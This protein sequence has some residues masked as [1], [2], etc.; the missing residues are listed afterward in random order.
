[1]VPYNLFAAGVRSFRVKPGVVETEL[2]AL[3]EVFLIDPHKDLTP[4][5]DVGT[6]LWERRL[7]HITYDVIN[8]FADGD[9]ADREAFYEE[10]DQVEGL[11]ARSS[12]EKV[13]R[14]E[15]MAMNVQ[16]DTQAL[17]AKKAASQVL[18]LDPVARKAIAAQFETNP[19]RWS[20]RFMDVVGDAFVD[21]LRRRDVALVAEPLDASARDLV[22]S[23]RFDVVFQ[24]H[25]ALGKSVEFAGQAARMRDPRAARAELTKGMFGPET[26]R[27]LL[28]EAIR[29]NQQSVMSGGSPIDQKAVDLNWLAQVIQPVL[30]ELGSE[31]VA[32]ILTILDTVTHDAL[33]NVLIG[34]LQRALV[35]REN[36]ILER[37]GSMSIDTARPL[38]RLLSVIKT[39]GSYDALRR[40]AQSPNATMRCEAIAFLAQSPEQLRDELSRL[41]E[42]PQA[43]L[44][45][46]AL[47]AMAFHQVRAAGPLLVKRVQDQSFNTVPI[48]ERRELFTALYSL[49]A[50]RAE[51]LAIEIVQKHGL[52]VDDALEE[53]R[54]LCA[55][56]LGKNSKEMAALEA[57]LAAS[58]RRWW[59]TQPL[60][61]AATL[62]AEAIAGRLGRRISPN[63]D[64]L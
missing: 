29:S 47:R 58:K 63:G 8:V 19:E 53:T 33:R 12:N 45:A 46:A 25:E 56:L 21:T 22:L 54:A 1:M 13:N 26:L 55:D 24:M 18:G 16:T 15:A 44:R 3:C 51:A 23:R 59:N 50:G 35:G 37:I 62:A 6:A 30:N 32:P 34:F 41:T 57:V 36:E 5:D 11:A 61:D 60:R 7:T 38:L 10:A 40:L 42:A 4:E 17:V 49:N 2:R 14:M 27:L 28:V 9:A 52:L 48:E 64:V 31:Y 39:Q 20:E 43:E